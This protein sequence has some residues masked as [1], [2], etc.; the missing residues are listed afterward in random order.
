MESS[1]K[2]RT[3][4]SHWAVMADSHQILEIQNKVWFSTRS[5]EPARFNRQ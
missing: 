2:V 5:H 3:E 4:D 1:R